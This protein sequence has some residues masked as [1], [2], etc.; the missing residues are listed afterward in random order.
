MRKST[1]PGE[2]EENIAEQLT[3]EGEECDSEWLR[4]IIATAM[5][6]KENEQATWP[7]LTD[8]DR[9]DEVFDILENSG[10]LALQ[11]AG[12]TQSNGLDDVTQFYHEEG[13]EE[14]GITGYCFYHGQDLERL[15]ETGDL[16]LAFGAIDGDENRGVDIGH[17][18]KGVFETAG[19][20][21]EWNGSMETRLLVKGIHWQRRTPPAD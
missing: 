6:E 16:Y 21:I 4:T 11:H 3:D 17:R 5:N 8:C 9:L 13:G 2:I 19:F 12:Y 14:S 18:I 7:D 10:I 20:D 1:L 15:L